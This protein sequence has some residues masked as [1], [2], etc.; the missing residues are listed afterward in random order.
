MNEEVQKKAMEMLETLAGKLGT[1]I[2]HLWGVLLKQAAVEG[3]D[4]VLISAMSA[5]VIVF[6]VVALYYV[7]REI[8]SLV[9]SDASK[10]DS[11]DY[12]YI[13]LLRGASGAA[14]FLLTAI[15]L[16]I[17]LSR[18]KIALTCFINPEYWAIR[19]IARLF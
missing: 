10:R 9:E 16:D 7:W 5:V 18:V 8:P 17:T 6:F 19:E 12:G 1:T 15:P 4:S 2:E 13:Y 3:V 11:D 14:W